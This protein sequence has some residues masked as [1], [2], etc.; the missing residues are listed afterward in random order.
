VRKKGHPRK[1]NKGKLGDENLQEEIEKKWQEVQK[2]MNELYG[3]MGR[4]KSPHSM[5]KSK[6]TRHDDRNGEG[7]QEG[8]PGPN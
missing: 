2:A 7:H 6:E 5:A 3:L 4:A 1:S 8:D